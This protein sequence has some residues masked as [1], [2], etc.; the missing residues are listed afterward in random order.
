[1]RGGLLPPAVVFAFLACE[2]P[3]PPWVGIYEI[4]RGEVYHRSIQFLADGSCVEDLIL[5]KGTPEEEQHGTTRCTY[6][7]PEKD[8]L[9]AQTQLT[10][11]WSF[12]PDT[13]VV[14]SFRWDR[15]WMVLLGSDTLWRVIPHDADRATRLA[16]SSAKMAVKREVQETQ[17]PLNDMKS[18]LRNLATAQEIYYSDGHWTY[19]KNLNRLEFVEHSGVTVTVVEATTTGWSATAK[20]SDTGAT[21]AIYYGNA[22]AIPPA[23]Q[24][25]VVSC[26]DRASRH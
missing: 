16:L 15:D 23:T 20:S 6:T 21:C 19:T 17:R 11:V 3:S 22:K 26:T 1:M 8:S 25:G 4:H 12:R 7:R 10:K 24:P 9:P 14:D 13:V 2:G 18:S 5:F